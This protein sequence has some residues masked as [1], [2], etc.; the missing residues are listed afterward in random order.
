MSV[1]IPYRTSLKDIGGTVPDTTTSQRATYTVPEAATKFG[2]ARGT[3]YELARA[4]TLPGVRKL[5]GRRYVVS[6]QEL[7]EFLAAPSGR[8]R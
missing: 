8:G 2:I 6:R 7:E 1:I 4:G 3:A 5:G